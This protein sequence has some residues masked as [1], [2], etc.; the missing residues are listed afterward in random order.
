MTRGDPQLDDAF[1]AALIARLDGAD[2]SIVMERDDGHVDVDTSDYF[3]DV[4]EDPLW[5]WI[6]NRI[7]GRVLDIGA[8]AGRASTR[9]QTEGFDVVALDVSPGCTEVCRRRGIESTFE[10][11]IEQLAASRHEAFDTLLAIGNNLGLLG[12]PDAAGAFLDSARSV[13]SSDVR[14]VGTMLDPYVTDDPLHL[15]YH[16]DNRRS[17][18]LA[19]EVRLRVRYRNL[20]TDWFSLLWVSVDELEEVCARH[21]WHVATTEPHGILYAAELRPTSPASGVSTQAAQRT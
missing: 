4:T 12:T 17:G 2:P 16:E 20:A 14:I 19:G 8:G 3:A 15:A 5:S 6:S 21:G 18:R 10:G 13:G 1:G 7:E 11:T 9:L